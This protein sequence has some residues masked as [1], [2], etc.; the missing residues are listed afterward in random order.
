MYNRTELKKVVFI[1]EDSF[2][3]KLHFIRNIFSRP[4]KPLTKH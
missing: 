4:L 2:F 1:F 3:K